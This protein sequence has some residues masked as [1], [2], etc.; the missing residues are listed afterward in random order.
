MKYHHYNSPYSATEKQKA[1]KLWERS[2]TEFVCHRY[3]CSDRS[4]RRWRKMYDG[5]LQS[6]ENKKKGPRKP[7]P[8]MQTKREKANIRKEISLHP[9]AGVVELYGILREKYGYKRHPATLSRYIKSLN[10]ASVKPKSKY[11]AKPYNTPANIGDKMQLDVKYVPSECKN[12]LIA[13]WQRYYQYT[14]LDEATRQRFI[15]P[16]EELSAWNTVDFVRRAIE[17]FG[18]TPRK[19]QTDNGIEFTYTTQSRTREHFFDTF[20]RQAHI[21][22]QLIKPRTPRHNGKVER[23]HRNDEERF[24]KYLK[25]NNYQDLVTK[26]GEYLNRS[27]NIPIS[28]LASVDG[29]RKWLSPNQKRQ[30]LEA[31]GYK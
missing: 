2:T 30:E 11:E 25:F 23:S 7:M 6:L 14:I 20:C 28:T 5:T 10:T 15:F 4:L 9:N 22:H 29:K 24:Y 21:L 27:N 18:Y 17:F 31:L 12:V 26:M 16:Y 13:G 8:T 3:H 1:L 19:I